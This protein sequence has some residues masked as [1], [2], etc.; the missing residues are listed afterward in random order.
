MSTSRYSGDHPCFNAGAKGRFGR[1]HLPVAISCNIRCNYCNRRYDCANESRPG[2][3]SAV[4]SPAQAGV[5]V[6]KVLEKEPRIKVA[7]IAG[8]GDPLANPVET[9]QTLRLLKA[10]FPDLL[11][12]LSTN[13]LALADHLEEL[14]D[15]GVSHVTVTVNAVN[16]DV[17]QRIYGWVRCGKVVYRGRAG[18]EI[19][20]ERQLEAIRLLKS[21]GVTVKVNTIV[22]PSVNDEH[23]GE[24]ARTMAALGVDVLN[25]MP[26]AP[27]AGTPFEGIPEPGAQ[28]MEKVRSEAEAHLPQM[29]HCTRCR[30]DAVGLLDEDLTRAMRG[31][32]GDCATG[33][34][35]NAEKPY[36]AVA[37]LE[38]V[39]VNL[40][41]GETATLQI[42]SETGDG[43][44]KIEER[45]APEPGGGI[46][47]WKQLA[48]TLRDCRAVLVGGIGENPR[49]VLLD[50]GIEPIVM[51][52]F[53]RLGLDAV[54]HGR[55]LAQFRARRNGCGKRAGCEGDGS[56][57]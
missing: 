4:L 36:V 23:V 52:G 11:L 6:K 3:T 30:A 46:L 39:L 40:H 32:L 12:C 10:R 38:G 45:D 5:Y 35:R 7:G 57:C 29:R 8:P 56:E 53:I 41:L 16:P 13:G 49:N 50:H 54:Y 44:R 34:S 47:R 28:L 51:N 22:V 24:V 31:C 26:M 9:L 1:V 20:L 14:L 55:N 18:A 48:E 21:N 17:G 43:F 42:W 27:N 15:A 37:T 25:C 2:V 33:S 19:L